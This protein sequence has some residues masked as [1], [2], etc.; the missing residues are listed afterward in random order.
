MMAVRDPKTWLHGII[1]VMCLTVLYGFSVFL[2]I[3][4]RFGFNYSVKQSQY[5]SI[6]VFAW[7][8][9][10][11]GVAGYLSDRYSRRF[12]TCVLCAPAGMI[13]YSILLGGGGGN[14]VPVGVKYFSCFLIA[15]CAWMLGG[16]NL[17][18][19]STVSQTLLD[20]S[21]RRVSVLDAVCGL[22]LK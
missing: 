14:A 3:I 12:L 9:L 19:L 16:G 15:S 4:L 17:A 8:S 20:V 13:G 1:Q 22:W 21:S 18:W 6:P 5:L 7:G 11:Y 2:P 10:V